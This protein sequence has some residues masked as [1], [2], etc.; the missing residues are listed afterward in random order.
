MKTPLSSSKPQE[1]VKVVVRCRPL[2]EKEVESNHASCV[3]M[4]TDRGLVEIKNPKLGPTDPVKTFTF[5]AVYD[6]N[7]KQL[8][9]YAETFAPLVESVLGGFN[10]TIFAY[11]QTGTGKTYT[12]EGIKDDA[13][14]KG[15][16]PNSFDQ[17]FGHISVSVGQQY[18]VR[19]S[20]L[21]I[22]QEEVRDLL[23]KDQKKRFELRE[24]PDTGVYVKDLSSFV[25]KSVSEIEHVMTVGNQNRTV[26]ATNMNE[27]SSRSHAIFILTV[28]CSEPDEEGQARIR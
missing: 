21:E 26:G 6:W 17:I 9:L 22:Y 8:D 25:C 2:N 3:E 28:E 18:L 14:R 19:A 24:R 10:G 12:M 5:D 20:Y 13:E 11:G 23:A 15:V 1:S 16:I 27:H 4:W 7:S